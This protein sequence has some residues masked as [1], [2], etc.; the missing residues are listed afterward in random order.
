MGS[1]TGQRMDYNG[2]GALG[3]QQ[4]M[5]TKVDPSIYPPGAPQAYTP[6]TAMQNLTTEYRATEVHLLARFEER[7]MKIGRAHV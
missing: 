5:P 4:H 7:G 6:T 2:V 3:H 1:T